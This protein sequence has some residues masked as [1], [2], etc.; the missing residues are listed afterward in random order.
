MSGS[1]FARG[2][3]LWCAL[4]AGALIAAPMTAGCAIARQAPQAQPG[5]N[6]DLPAWFVEREGKLAT[7][8]KPDLAAVPEADAA[9]LDALKARLDRMEADLRAAHQALL[10]DPRSAPAPAVDAAAF[11]RSARDSVEN[12]RR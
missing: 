10:A 8:G 5:E 6:A 4:A 3:G 11:D 2:F 12:A 9:A 1:A 7:I